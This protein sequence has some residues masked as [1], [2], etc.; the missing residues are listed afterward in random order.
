M[1][2]LADVLLSHP[3]FKDRGDTT[4]CICGHCQ[5]GECIGWTPHCASLFGWRGRLPQRFPHPM[6]EVMER[7]KRECDCEKCQNPVAC[8]CAHCTGTCMV[9]GRIRYTPHC[10][11]INVDHGDFPLVLPHAIA[12]NGM[13]WGILN[14]YAVEADMLLAQWVGDDFPETVSAS[15]MSGGHVIPWPF[16]VCRPMPAKARSVF[17]R[18]GHGGSC[19]VFPEIHFWH[20]DG[21]LV[22]FD[23]RP[24]EYTAVSFQMTQADADGNHEIDELDLKENP[25]PDVMQAALELIN[26]WATQPGDEFACCG[27]YQSDDQQWQGKVYAHDHHDSDWPLRPQFFPSLSVYSIAD[28]KMADAHNSMATGPGLRR[29]ELVFKPTRY[30]SAYIGTFKPVMEPVPLET[31]A[32]RSPEG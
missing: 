4:I 28:A 22:I 11:R 27:Y 3:Y 14:D 9:D 15:S 17:S 5:G 18:D 20:E 8:L 21:R 6:Q 31:P 1:I 30:E 24:V 25:N 23:G 16:L 29:W 32:E 2:D 13:A 7:L 26:A 12:N 10:Q 19:T